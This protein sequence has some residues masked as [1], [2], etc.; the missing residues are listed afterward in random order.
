MDGAQRRDIGEKV[1]EVEGEWQE[2]EKELKH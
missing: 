2:Q 1:L